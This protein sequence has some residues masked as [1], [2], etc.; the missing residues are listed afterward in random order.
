MWGLTN[1]RADIKFENEFL[2]FE[3]KFLG[4]ENNENFL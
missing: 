4:R 3:N 2:K 1:R